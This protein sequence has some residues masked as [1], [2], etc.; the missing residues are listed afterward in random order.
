MVY[1]LNLALKNIYAS[2]N[3]E[4]NEL[5]Y[6]VCHW[7]KEVVTDCYFIKNFSMNHSMR[8]TMF[9]DHCNLKMLTIAE[10]S[11]AFIIVMLKMFKQ[12]TCGI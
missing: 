12:I 7:I 9:N 2:K 4:A 1:M 6:G 8:L 3:N 10:T 5:T 11:F